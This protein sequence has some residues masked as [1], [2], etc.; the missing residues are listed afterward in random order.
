MENKPT[1]TSANEQR[2]NI[3]TQNNGVV[4]FQIAQRPDKTF[5]TVRHVNNLDSLIL[6]SN[7][8]SYT[9]EKLKYEIDLQ[10]EKKLRDEKI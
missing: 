1:L 2:I 4:I 10:I 9:I 5:F 7:F 8:L 6:L 3:V